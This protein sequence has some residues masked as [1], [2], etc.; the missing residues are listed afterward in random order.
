MQ[1]QTVSDLLISDWSKKHSNA[2]SIPTYYLPEVL[3]ISCSKD[4]MSENIIIR[5]T[6]WLSL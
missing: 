2:K 6:N 5:T 1:K 4:T 3:L